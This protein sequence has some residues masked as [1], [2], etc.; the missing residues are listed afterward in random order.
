M[1]EVEF[2]LLCFKEDMESN[3]GRTTELQL[4]SW[5]VYV[6]VF[7]CHCVRVFVQAVDGLTAVFG[8]VVASSL[9]ILGPLISSGL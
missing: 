2:F 9:G 5:Y 6:H 8:V 3:C 4:L 1:L 7:V